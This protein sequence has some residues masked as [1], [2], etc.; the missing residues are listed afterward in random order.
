M[1]AANHAAVQARSARQAR[2]VQKTPKKLNARLNF[3]TRAAAPQ[4]RWYK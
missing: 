3:V 1:T 2:A 4:G